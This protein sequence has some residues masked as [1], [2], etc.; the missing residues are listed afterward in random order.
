MNTSTMAQRPT[1]SEHA[2]RAMGT[3]VRLV[4]ES[5]G[6]GDATGWFDVVEREVRRLEQIFTRF[7]SA[8][9]LSRL[10]ARRVRRCSPELV[11]VLEL[12]QDARTKT[13]GR[14]D[15]TLLD[16]I[17]AAGYDR[18][19]SAVSAAPV[20]STMPIPGGSAYALNR[21]IGIVVLGAG[22]Q[23]DLGGIAKGWIADRAASLLAELGGA[24]VDAGGDISCTAR[25]DGQPW[26]IAVPGTQVDGEPAHLLLL[27]G[28]VATSGTDRRRWVDP[29]TGERRHHV[30]DPATGAPARSDITR[31]TTAAASCAE[32]EVAATA[33][34]LGGLAELDATAA[35]LGVPYLAL[36]AEGAT[37]TGGALA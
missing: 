6:D 5:P 34:L 8:S 28:G 2:F 30:I 17:V 29:G 21:D 24:L 19:F 27:E 3:D 15:P 11:E 7:S 23:V 20:A 4:L 26:S 37:H 12:A 16:A 36:D 31:V 18:T 32:A 33:L 25:I 14:F 22:A 9:E 1:R 13:G 10:N 35:T